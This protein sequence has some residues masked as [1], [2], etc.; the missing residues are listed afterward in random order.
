VIVRLVRRVMV[1]AVIVRLVVSTVVVRLVHRVEMT[2]TV[3]PI[4]AQMRSADQTM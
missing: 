4:R 3:A 2:V 1:T